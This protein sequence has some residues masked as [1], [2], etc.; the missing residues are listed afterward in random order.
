MSFPF[1]PADIFAQNIN[2]DFHPATSDRSLRPWDGADEYLL[3]TIHEDYGENIP[4]KIALVNDAYGALTAP[5]ASSAAM[6]LNDSFSSRD[7][8]KKNL[9]SNGIPSDLSF[10]TFLDDFEGDPDLIIMKIP[11]AL[12]LFRFQLSRL[13]ERINRPVPLLAAGPSK[14]LPVSFYESFENAAQDTS[15]SLIKKRARYYRGILLPSQEKKDFTRHF[16]WKERSFTTL[17]G[18]FSYGKP[19]QGS[20]FLLERFPRADSPRLI[21]DPGCG[22]GILGIEAALTW[23]EARII[24]T[25]D[26]ALAVA[27]TRLSAEANGVADRMDIRHTNILEGVESD[28]ADLVICN[29]PFHSQH[30]VQ[31]EQGFAF[32]KESHRVLKEGGQLFMVANRYLG[33]EKRLNSLFA[34]MKIIGQDRKF[35]LYMCRK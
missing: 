26:S 34:G 32:I 14:L 7:C 22:C 23:P 19:D 18:V 2:L 29:P 10:P 16:S 35:R 27:S 20:Q 11:K 13:A 24:S 6:S 30:R 4:R 25:D 21:V 17:P 3:E 5:L 1:P 33:Y 12:P 15:Y 9:Q 28:R 8:I 31:L